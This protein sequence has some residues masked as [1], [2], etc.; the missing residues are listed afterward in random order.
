VLYDEKLD[1]NRLFVV[2]CSIIT[3][4]FE[5]NLFFHSQKKKIY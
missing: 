1:K 2:F 4:W 5:D 3:F